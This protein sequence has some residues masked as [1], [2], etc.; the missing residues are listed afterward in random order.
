MT[1]Y[2][3]PAPEEKEEYVR[4]LFDQIAERYD[5]MNLVMSAGMWKAWHRR[6]AQHTGLRPG[7][8]VLDVAC[9]TGDLSLLAAA[10]VSPG[11]GVV[12]VDFSEGMLA[13]GRRRVAASPY[14]AM[15]DLRWGNALDLDFPDNSFDGVTMGWAMRNVRDID[16]C[17]AEALRVLKPGGRFISLD[18]AQPGSALVR[19][20]FAAWWRLGIPAIDWLVVHVGRQ[21]PVRPYTYLSRSLDQHPKVESLCDRFRRAGFAAAGYVT[22]NLGTVSIH[23]G[24]KPGGNAGADPPL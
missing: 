3:P 9:G 23:W 1:A 14:A 15:I 21:A 19:L 20:G 5:Q 18:A 2:R 6:F 7:Q 4:S 13:V 22:L 17:L 12:G 8:R 10:Q 16:R 24:S 11:G